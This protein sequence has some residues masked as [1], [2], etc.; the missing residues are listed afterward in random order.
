[1][2]KD[3]EVHLAVCSNNQTALPSQEHNHTYIIH[4]SAMRMDVG[5]V[6]FRQ[7]YCPRCPVHTGAFLTTTPPKTNPP[8]KLYIP[9]LVIHR[10]TK[11]EPE[12][13]GNNFQNEHSSS[14]CRYRDEYS[15]VYRHNTILHITVEWQRRR[16]RHRLRWNEL[17]RKSGWRVYIGNAN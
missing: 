4:S 9:C 1:M 7:T 10:S 12:Y 3:V 15:R 2:T 13:K 16:R 14:E 8:N 17:Y 6:F 5:Q 11:E